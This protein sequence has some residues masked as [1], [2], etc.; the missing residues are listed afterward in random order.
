MGQR[1]D[2]DSPCRYIQEIEEDTGRGVVDR[3]ARAQKKAMDV[4]G[5]AEGRDKTDFKCGACGC[6]LVNLELTNMAPNRCPY[7]NK[8]Q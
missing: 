6:P 2:V 5:I 4:V 1:A 8:H 3:L 7:K